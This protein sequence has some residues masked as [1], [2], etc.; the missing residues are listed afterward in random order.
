MQKDLEESTSKEKVGCSDRAETDSAAVIRDNW[1]FVTP[2]R[3][4]NRRRFFWSPELSEGQEDQSSD[5]TLWSETSTGATVVAALIR[6]AREECKSFSAKHNKNETL[7]VP[8]GQ[9]PH[10]H[11]SPISK[12]S[13][14]TLVGSDDS[15]KSTSLC[16]ECSI[17]RDAGSLLSV[18]DLSSISRKSE[19]NRREEVSTGNFNGAFHSTFNYPLHS[20][21]NYQGTNHL[22]ISPVPSSSVAIPSRLA[23]VTSPRPKNNHVSTV[24]VLS[25]DIKPRKLGCRCASSCQTQD[26]G[27]THFINK[28]EK[29]ISAKCHKMEN[30]PSSQVARSNND[31]ASKLG[32]TRENRKGMVNML[33]S[34]GRGDGFK[35]QNKGLH[36]ASLRRQTG[37][38]E[39]KTSASISDSARRRQIG[40]P[41]RC[42][43]QKPEGT[44]SLKDAVATAIHAKLPTSSE[45]AI[46]SRNSDACK[47]DDLKSTGLDEAATLTDPLH[48][49]R[50]DGIV[51][52]RKCAGMRKTTARHRIDNCLPSLL[53]FVPC[54][55]VKR[56]VGTVSTT[57]DNPTNTVTLGNVASWLCAGAKG[58]ATN[59]TTPTFSRQ[60]SSSFDSLQTSGDGEL[61]RSENSNSRNSAGGCKAKDIARL[62][63]LDNRKKI[64]TLASGSQQRQ[65][66]ISCMTQQRNDMRRRLRRAKPVSRLH[67][68][69]L[70]NIG[71]NL[72]CR[73]EQQSTRFDND[74]VCM[75]TLGFL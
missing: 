69:D 74:I 5:T 16:R 72:V 4:D 52:T 30:L 60:K 38:M 67:R 48:S 7:L 51:R 20:T 54:K 9:S 8:I 26:L 58:T 71:R 19:M 12:T 37:Q 61:P 22:D 21:M 31:I 55:S 17:V 57:E 70:K 66:N 50:P 28:P 56:F 73:H 25:V 47:T 15:V 2:L 11:R 46:E 34:K 13:A 68:R 62:S 63:A 29:I 1:T 75:K 41:G 10:E 24:Q 23:T 64:C 14:P 42:Q 49:F 27:Q 36:C 65:E 45:T 39:L 18:D 32:K 53:S 44:A 33:R 59:D 3:R 43:F 40:L 6:T 35:P